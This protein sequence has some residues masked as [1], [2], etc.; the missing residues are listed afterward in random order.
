MIKSRRL[1][2]ERLEDR[3][4]PA[5]SGVAWPDSEHLTLS[6]V[7]DGTKVGNYTSSLLST[8]DAVASR[9]VWQREI[10]RA[11]QTWAANGNLN[12]GVVADGGQDLGTGG[13]FQGDDRFGD[14]RIAAAPLA[15]GTLITNTAFQWSGTTWS[16]DIVLN[17][18]YLFSTSDTAGYTDL[19]TAML[20]EAGNVLGVLD[21]R[22]DV[23]SGVYYQ[24]VGPRAGIN[25]ADVADIQALY[26]ARG[27]DGYDAAGPNN[28]LAT[29][30]N[31]G[32]PL[33]GFNLEADVSSPADAD[34]YRFTIPVLSPAVV[35]LQVR[36]I[37]GGLSTLTP[38]LEVYDANMQLVG[39]ATD[40]DPLTGEISVSVGGGQVSILGQVLGGSDYYVR[41][42]GNA[43]TG[44]GVGGY[45]LDVAWQLSNG[46]LLSSLGL[47]GQ[48]VNVDVLA[49][50]LLSTAQALP[51]Y[52]GPPSDARFDYT[53][54][55]SISYSS[56]TDYYKVQAPA[57]AGAQKMNVLV[58]ALARCRLLPKVEAF[59]AAGHPVAAK[60]LGNE[61][62]TYSVELA[63]T[64]PGAVYYVK[65]SALYP[66]GSHN[67]GNYFLGVDFGTQPATALRAMAGG[68]LTASAPGVQ[69]TLTVDQNRLYQFI[70]GAAAGAD[71]QVKMEILDAAGAVVF[72]LRSYAGMSASS[73]HVYLRAGTYTVRFSAAA[74]PGAA[75][76]AVNFTLTGRGISD[77]IGPQP[78]GGA[79]NDEGSCDEWSGA[80]DTPAG[81]EPSWDTPYYF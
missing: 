29:A 41:V 48:L 10:V 31:L 8:L 13:A 1:N 38:T 45:K 79:G 62:G 42:A 20:N 63:G 27:A 40:T 11:F 59:D 56:D 32:T 72:T 67:I 78:E 6:F 75:L 23:T 43:G 44:F 21:S 9:S 80:S 3:C 47:G 54:K 22:T 16:G 52:L 39:S 26:G 60:L 51:S 4:T 81:A 34:F 14:I 58:W 53:F 57:I 76:P 24:Y 25:G 73:G 19:Y 71:A 77:P 30:T 50:D 15:P 69:R 74:P 49:N 36:V 5:T 18:T 28:S 68:T 35:G 12:V 37:T 66:G 70:L 33:A 7:P 65:V 2:L 17:S 64:T 61:N 55:A 46:T